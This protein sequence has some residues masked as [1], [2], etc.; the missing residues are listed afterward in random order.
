MESYAT[1]PPQSLEP[2]SSLQLKGGGRPPQQGGGN[3]PGP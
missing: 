1:K 3:A 2:S